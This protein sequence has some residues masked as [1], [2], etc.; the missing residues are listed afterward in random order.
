[1]GMNL[2][3]RCVSAVLCLLIALLFTTGCSTTSNHIGS[4]RIQLN[5]GSKY[6]L[7]RDAILLANRG[8]IDSIENPD[9]KIEDYKPYQHYNPYYT[10]PIGVLRAGTILQVREIKT[11]KNGQFRAVGEI[12]SGEYKRKKLGVGVF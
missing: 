7:Q 5:T 9:Y 3:L 6:L 4:D 11:S 10:K 8:A 1:M 2:S 12:L